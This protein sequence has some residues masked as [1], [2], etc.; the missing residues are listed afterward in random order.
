MVDVCVL[1]TVH[2]GYRQLKFPLLASWF[3]QCLENSGSRATSRLKNLI[4][5][6]R[7]A[8]EQH[9]AQTGCLDAYKL[10]QQGSRITASYVH[11]L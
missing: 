6:R 1:K 3:E 11:H 2:A 5:E 9:E 8:P 10:L 4:H 7:T